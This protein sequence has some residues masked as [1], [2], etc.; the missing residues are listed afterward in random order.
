MDAFRPDLP[1][2]DHMEGTRGADGRLRLHDSVL[3]EIQGRPRISKRLAIVTQQMAAL[4]RTTIVKG[5]KD[6]ANRGWRRSPLGGQHGMHYYLWWSPQGTRQTQR[7]KSLERGTILIRAVRHHDDHSPLSVGRLMDYHTLGWEDLDGDRN[8]RCFESPWTDVQRLFAMDDG[9]VR[10]VYGYPGSGKT[11]ALWRAVEARSS[12]RTLYLSWSRSLAEQARA[13]FSA[14]APRDSVVDTRAFST[15]LGEICGEDVRHQSL[16]SSRVEFRGAFEWWKLSDHQGP[17]RNRMDALHAELRALLFGCAVPGM[18]R[19]HEGGARLSDSAYLD[20]GVSKVGRAAGNLALELVRRSGWRGWYGDVFPELAAASR[21]L[22]RLNAGHLPDGLGRFDR[23]VVDEVQDLTLLETAVVVQYC[24][25]LA[26]KRGYAPWLLLAFDD[27]QTVRPSG[28]DAGRLNRLLH[29]WL[30][31]PEEFNLEHN[32]RSPGL[33]AGV[34]ERASVLY[35]VIRKRSR[36]VDQRSELMDGGGASQVDAR[37]IYAEIKDRDEARDLVAALANLDEIA[38]VTPESTVP[39]WVPPESRNAILTPEES[40]GLE[41]SSVCVLDLGSVLTRL[42]RGVDSQDPLEIH[43]QRTAIDRLRVALSRATENLI[44]VDIAPDHRSRQLC[45]ELLGTPERFTAGDLVELFEDADYPPDERIFTR[46][47]DA[48]RLAEISPDRAWERSLQALRL[49]RGDGGRA[50]VDDQAVQDEVCITLLGI[51]ARRLAEGG[52]D[53]TMRESITQTAESVTNAWGSPAQYSVIRELSSW[54]A[55]RTGSPLD[56]LEAGLEL[57]ERDRVWLDAALASVRQQLRQ[58]IRGCAG[59]LSFAHRFEGRFEPILEVAGIVGDVAKEARRL[60][61]SALDVLADA[62]EFQSAARVLKFVESPE[63]RHLGIV[64]EGTGRYSVAAEAF[65]RAGMPEDALRN[66]RKGGQFEKALRHA[67]RKTKADLQWMIRTE[68]LMKRRPD[69]IQDR[70]TVAE[71]KR[72][73]RATRMPMRK[74]LS[75]A[76]GRRGRTSAKFERR[77]GRRAV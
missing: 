38:M 68:K 72:L 45:L 61:G 56:L 60:R 33:I 30:T 32:V 75:S 35:S 3:D 57:D 24:R 50:L 9:P 34:V 76:R 71:R 54:T 10:L 62:G 47:D 27:G 65:E 69:R 51:G 4:G 58:A 1:T 70:L 13:R 11:V 12:G 55:D 20:G 41:Y 42:R 64:S 22:D 8:S 31:S 7:F 14:F 16:A 6:P 37:L 77:R 46:T 44:L 28:F 63:P 48:R 18:Y 40:K 66:W 36:P 49:L 23:I 52:L 73:A 15:F 67:T 43:E 25:V 53:G 59:D 74:K 5:C 29:G 2:A 17:W 26:S 19:C 21:A 39:G